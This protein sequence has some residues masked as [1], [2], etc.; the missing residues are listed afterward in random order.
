MAGPAA[1]DTPARRWAG[2]GPYYAMFPTEFADQVIRKHSD[3]GDLVLDPFAGRGTSIFSAATQK[4][5]AVGI[6][7]SPVGF[8]YARTKLRPAEKELIQQ[9][10]KAIGRK[11]ASRTIAEAASDLPEFFT[12]CF[13]V[14]VRRFLVSARR[15]LAW[16]SSSI[17]RT[18]MAMI[19]VYLHGK[20]GAALSNQMRQTKSMSPDY[21]IR[22]WDERGLSPPELDPVAF[23][24]SRLNW[25]YARGTPDCEQ[26]SVYLGNSLQLLPRLALRTKRGDL[27]K[28]KL[29]FT[30][31]PYYGVTN[32]HYD[33]W[34]RLWL[35]GGPPG[36][37]R[38]GNGR[39]GKFEH[40][41][42]Y[43]ALLEQIFRHAKGVMHR[44]AVVYVRTDARK[45]TRDTTIDA[46]RRTF[47][48]KSLS[49]RRRPIEGPSQTHLFGDFGERVGE[50]DLVLQPK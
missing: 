16:R 14:N 9:R 47:P 1:Y 21:A 12:R 42:N 24:D 49:I 35:L 13:S 30:S 11:A 34:L 41:E 43:K 18:T 3:E 28:A 48:A 22:W 38:S 8:L 40:R 15:H 32:Y 17:D 33:Q 25:R 31:P 2:F 20:R 5:R 6:E 10:I 39:C 7:I 50:V 26:S 29:L 27:P 45:F 23:F 44:D 4:R 19:L 36:A 46:L 37:E